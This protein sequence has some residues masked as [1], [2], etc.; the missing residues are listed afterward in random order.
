MPSLKRSSSLCS[1]ISLVVPD[2]TATFLPAKSRNDA[3]G[4]PWLT[5]TFVLATKMIGENAMC[6]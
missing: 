5:I 4:E 2:V 3:I 6:F 1:A